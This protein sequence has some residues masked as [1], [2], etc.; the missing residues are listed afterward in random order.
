LSLHYIYFLIEEGANSR[1]DIRQQKL[2]SLNISGSDVSK[3]DPKLLAR[4]VVKLKEITL[5]YTCLT[6]EQAKQILF[7]LSTCSN[8]TLTK[9]NIGGND[10]SG[11]DPEVLSLGLTKVARVSLAGTSLTTDQIIS[12][13]MRASN[14]NNTSSSSSSNSLMRRLNLSRNNLAQV[15]PQVL[16]EGI[17]CLREVALYETNLT[18]QQVTAIL[19]M[20][21][22][23]NKLRKLHFGVVGCQLPDDELVRRARINITHL[24]LFQ[25][26]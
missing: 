4:A 26:Q 5:T 24:H 25:C 21:A 1:P 11:S 15:Q 16:A 10:L 20:V 19:R 22:V 2:K 23:S 18:N 6:K 14:N 8:P 9:L 13:L 17:V 12:L 3:V 7:A